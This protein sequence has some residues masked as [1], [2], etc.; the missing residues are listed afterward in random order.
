MQNGAPLAMLSV[1]A[2][3]AFAGMRHALSP[4]GSRAS[5]RSMAQIKEANL[6]ADG[7]FFRPDVMAIFQTRIE[8]GPFPGG[9][10]VTSEQFTS[11]RGQVYPRRYT[12]R[13]ALENGA[14]ETMG[15][16]QEHASKAE[17][18][19]AAKEAT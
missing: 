12:V 18:V 1:M 2:I 8:A 7:V 19:R 14:V 9:L 4:Q 6:Q 17:A 5:Y 16:F 3:S 11:M 15:Q 13:R 10:F